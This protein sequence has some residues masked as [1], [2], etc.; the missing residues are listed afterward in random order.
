M[1]QVEYAGEQP[2]VDEHGLNTFCLV[3]TKSDQNPANLNRSD[4]PVAQ[5]PD[6]NAER[7]A[8]EAKDETAQKPAEV[9]RGDTPLRAELPAIEIGKDGRLQ[10]I[11]QHDG[12]SLAFNY[13]ES[14]KVK[15]QSVKDK[16]G[17]ILLTQAVS[18]AYTAVTYDQEGTIQ[19][20]V[21]FDGEGRAA[22]ITAGNGDSVSFKYALD[23][24]VK[25]KA[26]NRSDGQPDR[27]VYTNGDVNTFN[28][29]RDGKPL[30]TTTADSTGR[31]LETKDTSGNTTTMVYGNDGMQAGSVTVSDAGKLVRMQ[32]RNGNTTK[33]SYNPDGS[34]ASRVVTDAKNNAVSMEFGGGA[35]QHFMY[36]SRGAKIGE[37]RTD[38]GG[39]VTGVSSEQFASGLGRVQAR[40]EFD[41][42]AGKIAASIEAGKGS[43][44]RVSDRDLVRL[45]GQAR[46]L[47]GDPAQAAADAINKSLQEQKSTYSVSTDAAKVT[48][49]VKHFAPAQFDF[50]GNLP[51][52]REKL[53]DSMQWYF[54]DQA[55]R[56]GFA[57]MM[58]GFEKRMT[59]SIERREAAGEDKDA[60]AREVQQ[61]LIQTY[62]ELTRLA[63][64]DGNHC[65]KSDSLDDRQKLVEAFIFHAM[66]PENINGGPMNT[67]GWLE[68]TYVTVG[69][70]SHPEKMA[71]VVT[72][73]SLTGKFTDRNGKTYM[74]TAAELAVKGRSRGEGWSVEKAD[75]DSSQPSPVVYRLDVT[76]AKAARPGMRP[77]HG[78]SNFN[79]RD[80]IMAATSDKPESFAGTLNAATRLDLARHG[81]SLRSM[82]AH[83]GTFELKKVGNDWVLSQGDQYDGRDHQIGRIRAVDLTRWVKTGEGLR[84]ERR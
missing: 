42:T 43:M 82:P 16:E 68:P 48:E 56:D 18:G 26:F 37:V 5:K 81:G 83:Y 36:D 80:A 15:S 31:V 19:S 62:A 27:V 50:K 65:Q 71:K 59:D 25:E 20:K 39:R 22:K 3:D 1:A 8:G 60:V 52:A 6:A 33:Y 63:D 75:K 21:E 57:K 17:K 2:A 30:G 11:A 49:S 55:G 47:S 72:A 53:Q 35:S 10:S 64:G 29:D 45:Y 58:T 73:V 40:I 78:G 41:R 74:Y 76:L 7:R 23:G 61:K 14:G 34:I 79:M 12:G 4:E 13:D 67:G 70:G 84:V 28:Y 46:Q 69:F 66:N 38:A 9:Q 77:L 44:G 51:E 32:D 24:S 54:A